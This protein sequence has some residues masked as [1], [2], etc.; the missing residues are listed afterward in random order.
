MSDLWE[1]FQNQTD[2]FLSGMKMDENLTLISWTCRPVMVTQE[3]G[4]SRL[5]KIK[6]EEGATTLS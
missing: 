1:S 5:S 3:V 6:R 2:T 4:S